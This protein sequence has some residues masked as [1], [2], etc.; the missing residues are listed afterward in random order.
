[1][2]YQK[3]QYEYIS[4]SNNLTTT[5]Q[6]TK[7][8]NM[9]IVEHQIVQFWNNS[10]SNIP[11]SNCARLNSATSNSATLKATSLNNCA[12]LIKKELL[13]QLDKVCFTTFE[14]VASKS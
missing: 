14:Y 13:Q 10:T 9:K 6:T 5:R 3:V 2:Q 8:C 12:S 4:K 1:M 7:Q 11:A